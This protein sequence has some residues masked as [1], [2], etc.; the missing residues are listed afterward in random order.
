MDSL[1]RLL[2]DRRTIRVGQIVIG[3][4]FA[5]ASLSKIGDLPAFALQVH[6]F[7]IAP[8]WS[9]NL[10]AMALPWVELVAALSLLLGVRPRA[11][12][13]VVTALMAGFTVGVILAMARGLDFECGCFGTADHTRVGAIKLLENLAML[14]VSL[15]ALRWPVGT[16]A[17][18]SAS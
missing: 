18:A 3:L 4:V 13:V 8:V 11:G 16:G 6:N 2:L 14:G 5:T 10:I 12:A 1:R 17:S 9:E 15:V 7:R